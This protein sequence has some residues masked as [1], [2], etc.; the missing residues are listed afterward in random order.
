MFSGLVQRLPSR[1][2]TARFDFDHEKYSATSK[3]SISKYF[4][5]KTNVGAVNGKE[6]G[7]SGRGWD[8]QEVQEVY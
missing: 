6:G 7:A 3:Y 8:F 1:S 4:P 2:C 5:W